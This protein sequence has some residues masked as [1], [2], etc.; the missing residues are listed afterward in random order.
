M[1]FVGTA[2]QVADRFLEYINIGISSF[3]LSGYPNLEEAT[4]SGNAL[5]PAVRRKLE[6]RRQSSQDIAAV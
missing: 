2:E 3:I 4:I 6:E 1:A 5:I